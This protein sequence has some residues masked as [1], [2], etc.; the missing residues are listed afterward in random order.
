MS[1]RVAVRDVSKTY[2]LGKVTVT[3]L[4]GVSLAVKAGSSW[5][6]RGR[7]GVGRRRC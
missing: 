5:R 6:W 4:D 2:R 1:E 3:A 7:R